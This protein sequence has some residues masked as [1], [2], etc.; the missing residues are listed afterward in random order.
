MHLMEV[1]ES[2]C[3]VMKLES[4]GIPMGGMILAGNNVRLWGEV[5]NNR[6]H[7]LSTQCG[8]S[9]DCGLVGLY[10]L[11]NFALRSLNS[12]KVRGNSVLWGGSGHPP[13]AWISEERAACGFVSPQGNCHVRSQP[14]LVAIPFGG[15]GRGQ[16]RLNGS[17]YANRPLSLPVPWM[18]YSGVS[19]LHQL[20]PKGSSPFTFYEPSLNEICTQI[21]FVYPDIYL[22]VLSN[23]SE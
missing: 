8:C 14:D 7:S 2:T 21:T 20:C 13:C 11:S 1:T 16:C 15:G 3:Y 5:G 4:G 6:V 17:I 12:T 10:R 19:A 23:V 18:F 9:N 22:H